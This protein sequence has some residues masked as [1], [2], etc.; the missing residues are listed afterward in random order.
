MQIK[1]FINLKSLVITII[2]AAVLAIVASN[3]ISSRFERIESATK[4]NIANQEATLL[5]IAETTA[6]NG[7]DSI[8]ESIV[9]DCSNSE[10][11]QFETY[12]N[13]LNS[14]LSKV[15]LSE[16]ERLFG[17]CGSFYSERKSVMVSRLVREIE[18]Y[19]I[20]VAQLS[21][22]LNRDMNS[23]YQVEKWKSLA[24]SEKE[25]SNL[26]SSLVQHQDKIITTLLAGKS[27]N[28]EEIINILAEVKEVQESLVY[29]NQQAT[30]LREELSSL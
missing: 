16:L 27:Q 18:V 9:K 23:D 20:Y 12:L 28:S 14:G 26:F 13:R 11:D 21:T 15:E 5:V 25:Q 1:N 4:L 2:A 6:R 8:T 17:R 29:A 24:E 19:E 22:V 10:R 3:I 30:S 7:A